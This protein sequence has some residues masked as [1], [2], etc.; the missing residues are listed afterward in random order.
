MPR[1]LALVPAV[2]ATFDED[3]KADLHGVITGLELRAAVADAIDLAGQPMAGVGTDLYVPSFCILLTWYFDEDELHRP[4]TCRVAWEHPGG[5]KET[6]P[7]DIPAVATPYLNIIG[8][9]NGLTV[10]HP[11]PHTLRAEIRA[12]GEA[13]WQPCGDGYVVLVHEA[14]SATTPADEPVA[15]VAGH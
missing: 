4:W 11:G 9:M 7:I 10:S 14:A 5:R 2:D 1:L 12:A 6:A 8:Q 3:G 15:S 13:A